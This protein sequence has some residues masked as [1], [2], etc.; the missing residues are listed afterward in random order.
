MGKYS[1]EERNERDYYP[2]PL[3]AVIPLVPYLQGIKNFAEPFSGDGALIQ[4]LCLATKMKCTWAFDIEPQIEP[5][6]A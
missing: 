4:H 2:T 3:K 5:L 1:N 6:T